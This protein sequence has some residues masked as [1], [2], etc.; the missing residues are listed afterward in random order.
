MSRTEYQRWLDHCVT[1]YA[2]DKMA[3]LELGREQALALSHQSFSTLL[4]N[5]LETPCHY[6][7]SIV[8]AQ[9][10]RVGTLWFAIQSEWGVTSAFIYDLEIVQT[11]RRLGYAYAAMSALENEV[12]SL[13]ASRIALHVFGHN[14]GAK[15]LYDQLGYQVTDISMAKTIGP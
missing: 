15:S 5:G 14:R 8:D 1:D 9:E 2:N 12:S 11:Q 3:A 10:E 7:H 13:G 6:L 4:P